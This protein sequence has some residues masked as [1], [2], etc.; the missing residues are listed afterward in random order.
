MSSGLVSFSPT[1]QKANL[2]FV[3]FLCDSVLLLVAFE[4][5]EQICIFCCYFPLNLLASSEPDGPLDKLLGV[6]NYL[7]SQDSLHSWWQERLGLQSRD[8]D[9][10]RHFFVIILVKNLFKKVNKQG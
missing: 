9:R 7:G 6:L 2:A 8:P 5:D 1:E 10:L 4:F 3:Y